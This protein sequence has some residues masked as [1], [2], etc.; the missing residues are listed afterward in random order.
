MNEEEKERL[1]WNWMEHWIAS[2]P[3]QGHQPLTATT[4]DMSDKT[5]EMEMLTPKGSKT[6]HMTP[7]YN[8]DPFDSDTSLYVT[9]RSSNAVSNVNVPSYMAPTQSAKAK[10]RYQCQGQRGSVVPS[11]PQ[12]SKWNS[13]TR[14]SVDTRMGCDSSS[15]GGGTGSGLTGTFLPHR[16]PSHKVTR[17][18][19]VRRYGSYSPDSSSYGGHLHQPSW[20]MES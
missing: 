15:S 10:V 6:I 16:S 13:S 12:G 1:G 8:N 7:N 5:V 18:S 20:T 17:Y 3:Y 19:K 14:R 11:S 9:K 4:D 2:R